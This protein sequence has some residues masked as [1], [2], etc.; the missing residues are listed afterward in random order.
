MVVSVRNWATGNG[1]WAMGIGNNSFSSPSVP[2]PHCPMTAGAPMSGDPKTALPPPC[3]MPIAP[4]PHSDT[5]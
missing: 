4:C 3:P 2:S 1:Q 5:R